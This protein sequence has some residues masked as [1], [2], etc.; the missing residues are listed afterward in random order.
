M[1]ASAAARTVDNGAQPSARPTPQPTPRP[2]TSTRPKTPLRLVPAPAPSLR[3]GPFIVLILALVILGTLGLLVLNTVI[4]ADSFR[5]EQ[6]I[7]RNAELAV[8][9]Q[10][11]Q[12]Q[13]NEALSPE[14]LAESARDLGMIP[15]GQ[16]GFILVAPD[17]SI[18]IQGNPVPAG[19]L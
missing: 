18:V 10:G 5:M 14:A 8:T 2:Q 1:A 12:R 11:L 19:A 3:R 17:G 7:Q 13:V 9:E 4:A 15:A 6:L 16:P